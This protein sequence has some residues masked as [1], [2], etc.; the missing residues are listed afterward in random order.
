MYYSI[1][2]SKIRPISLFIQPAMRMCC[3]TVSSVTC[4]AIPYFCVICDMSG[5][6]LLLCHLWHVWFTVLL[7]HLLHV[8]LNVLL[9]HLWHVW[10]YRITVSS[11]TCL[12]YRFT[13]SSVTCLVYR[14]TVSS[15]SC[16]IVQ[17]YCVICDMS[18]LPY[19]CAI[20]DMFVCTVFFHIIFINGMI[21]EGKLLNIKFDVWISLQFCLEHCSL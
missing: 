7:C 16:L 6:T 1:V 17:Y 14:I 2:S 13:V 10:L 19:Y 18:R 5:C 15:V 20:S 8:W 11:V 9:C 3:I 21:F 12:V 4:L